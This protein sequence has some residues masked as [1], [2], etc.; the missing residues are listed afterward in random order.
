MVWEKLFVFY[1]KKHYK[2]LDNNI[3]DIPVNVMNDIQGHCYS[4]VGKIPI[5]FTA[6]FIKGIQILHV[7]FQKNT[8]SWIYKY[9]ELWEEN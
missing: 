4:P 8:R 7:L 6:P 9:S 1:Y 3:S 2:Y 5:I